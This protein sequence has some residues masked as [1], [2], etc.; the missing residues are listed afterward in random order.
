MKGVEMN[1]VRT[2]GRIG[3]KTGALVGAGQGV[4]GIGSTQR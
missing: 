1:G 2:G 3:I 4:R